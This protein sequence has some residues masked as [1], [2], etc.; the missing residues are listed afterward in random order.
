MNI[1]QFLE[2]LP[3][4]LFTCIILLIIMM[5]VPSEPLPTSFNLMVVGVL[6]TVLSLIDLFADDIKKLKEYACGCGP[7]TIVNKMEYRYDDF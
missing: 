2:N 3:G 1:K 6:F 5:T 4:N 7:T